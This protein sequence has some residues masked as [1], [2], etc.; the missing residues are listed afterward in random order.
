MNDELFLE[1]LGGSVANFYE[2]KINN[3]NDIKYNT[4]NNLNKSKSAVNQ[5]GFS[6]T[7]EN[8]VSAIDSEN[9]ELNRDTMPY[10]VIEYGIIT[11]TETTLKLKEDSI[12]RAVINLSITTD[13]TEHYAKNKDAPF[14]Y[15][16]ISDKPFNKT[17]E[18]TLDKEEYM[19]ELNKIKDNLLLSEKPDRF[20]LKDINILF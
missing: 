15:N 5:W 4:Y 19:V 14:L 8:I 11:D 9:I 1:N 10:L 13:K 6:I 16:K 3:Q 17:N 18:I 2:R 20:I 7:I 12:C